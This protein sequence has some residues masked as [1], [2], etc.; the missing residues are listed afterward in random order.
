VSIGE[1]LARKRQDAGLTVTQVSERTRIRETVIR[2]IEC[3]DFSICGGNFYAR[4]HVRSIA[5]VIGLDPEP[6]VREY[7]DAHGGAPQAISAATAFEPETP[8]RFRERRSPNWTAAM[9]VAL[10]LVLIYGIVQAFGTDGQAR[11]PVRI[12]SRVVVATPTKS[13]APTKS[14]PVAMAAR[15]EVTLRVKAKRA[16]WVSVRDSNGKLLFSGLLHAGDT[17]EWSAKKKIRILIGNGG[18]VRLTVN[19]KDLGSPG[20]SGQVIPLNFGPGDPE[21]A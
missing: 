5:R 11:T 3:D 15:K 21:I 2:A 10:T 20:S 7:D 6:L 13:P 17:K 18:G 1:A 19:G 14:A 16:S 9:A 4:G 12:E 8:V